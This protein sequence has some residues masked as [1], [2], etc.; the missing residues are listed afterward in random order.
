MHAKNLGFKK[1]R[2]ESAKMKGWEFGNHVY[3]LL[4]PRFV[5][6]FCIPWKFTS[7]LFRQFTYAHSIQKVFFCYTFS[8]CARYINS[9]AKRNRKRKWIV[10]VF[11]AHKNA[12][13]LHCV[14]NKMCIVL[15]CRHVSVVVNSCKEM[16]WYKFCFLWGVGV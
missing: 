14:A 2:Q 7:I 13:E 15:L 6:F 1:E 4:N 5:T 16:R 12:V 3:L 11:Q 10:Y 8:V 9:D